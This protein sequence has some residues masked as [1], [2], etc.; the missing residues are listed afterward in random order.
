LA[1][2]KKS[3]DKGSK[4]HLQNFQISTKRSTEMSKQS[5]LYI[6]KDI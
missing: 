6:A 5:S 3:S 2:H 4:N 1:T